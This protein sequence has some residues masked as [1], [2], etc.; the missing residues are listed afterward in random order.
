MTDPLVAVTPT[1]TDVLTASTVVVF[2]AATFTPLTTS[3]CVLLRITDSITPS[4]VFD[5][6]APVADAPA[7]TVPLLAATESD[8]AT[9]FASTSSC[10]TAVTL[11]APS[12]SIM[13]SS[14]YRAQFVF[15]EII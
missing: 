3:A 2:E 8:A 12:V 5:T 9:P 11:S 14:I 6:T 10:E 13:E 7:A 1:P 15:D 4:T